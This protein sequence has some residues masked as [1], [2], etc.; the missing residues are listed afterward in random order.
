MN[1]HDIV[2]LG[3]GTDWCE[4]SLMGFR[5]NPNVSIINDK[6]IIR[7]KVAA[8][9]VNAHY[10]HRINTKIELPLKSIWYR[11]FD[12]YINKRHKLT[13]NTIV[14][15]Y[16]R[17][18]FAYDKKFLQYLR[19]RHPGIKLVYIFTN[20]VKYT[21]AMDLGYLYNL[22]DW[23]DVVFAFDPMDA[24][25]YGFAYSP[26]IYDADLNYRKENIESKEPL[27]FYV[28]QAKDRLSGLLS[29]YEK[30]KALGISCDFHIANV[31]EMDIRHADEIVYNKFMTYQE[32]VDSIQKA[33]CLIDVIQGDSSGLTIK[34]CE[35]V[36]YDKKLITTN[37]H[38]IEYP[39]YD[40]RYIRV[41]ESPDDI[42]IQFLTE[43]VDVHYSEEGKKYFSA[44][45]FLQRL[46]NELNKV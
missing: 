17:N 18:R 21:A 30:L 34:T 24:G 39:F 3:N 19:K 33:T 42:N 5:N 13:D 15:F 22:R 8:K 38:V 27:V 4:M 43:N 32:C 28:G 10:S 14:A 26:L 31:K 7:G 36:C 20:I 37:K 45:T 12:A 2:F 6:I 1:G 35:A 29:Y 16:D 44:E 23:Y 11:G 46:E 25:K 41:V 9:L 40:P